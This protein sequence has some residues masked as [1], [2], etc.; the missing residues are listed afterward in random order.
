M[1]RSGVIDKQQEVLDE[2]FLPRTVVVTV[3][4]TILVF[5][6]TVHLNWRWAVIYSVISLLTVANFYLLYI[7]CTRLMFQEDQKMV[8]LLIFLKC[9]AIIGLGLTFLLIFGFDFIAFIA[10]LHT[11]FIVIILRA[12]GLYVFTRQNPATRTFYDT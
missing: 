9:F 12:L 8:P 2:R 3:L 1:T 5:L 6:I 11:L 7:I 10:G 4:V